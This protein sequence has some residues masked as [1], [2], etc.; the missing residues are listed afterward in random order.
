MGGTAASNKVTIALGV[1][2]VLA[3]SIPL[4]AMAG[5][6]P[7]ASTPT[8]DPAPA[9]MGW[10]IGLMFVSAGFIVIVRG[11]VGANGNSSELPATAPPALR[12]LNDI[13]GVGIAGGLAMLFSWVA[14]GAGPRHFSMGFNG[15]WMPLSNA[16]LGRVAF[17]FGAMLGW[18][19]TVAMTVVTMRK[20]RR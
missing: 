8:A 5:I 6:L 20:W 11:I 17:G 15:L 1:M 9:W 14:F 16:T 2:T 19:I 10:L 3:G 7:R 13:I 4:L 18:C 12:A